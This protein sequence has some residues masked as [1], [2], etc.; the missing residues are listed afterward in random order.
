MVL[1]HTNDVGLA[2][3]HRTVSVREQSSS[4]EYLEG[5][6]GYGGLFLHT[7]SVLTLAHLAP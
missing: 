6:G 3:L 5:V 1:S 7:L 2:T 4:H